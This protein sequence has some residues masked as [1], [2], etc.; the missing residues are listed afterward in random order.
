LATVKTNKIVPV[1]TAASSS[2]RAY[3]LLA[4][5]ALCWAGNMG[6]AS[7]H[8]SRLA[9]D[10]ELL[11]MGRV[12]RCIVFSG[13]T[14]AA[15]HARTLLPHWRL[16][17]AMGAFGL[18]GFGALVYLAA[19]HTSSINLSIIQGSIPVFVLI[20]AFLFQ[21]KRANGWMVVGVALTL[22]GILTI[23]T[24]GEWSR[25]LTLSFNI[26]DVFVLLACVMYAGYAL[27][28]P[29]RPDMPALCS[30]PRWRWWG[31]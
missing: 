16:V 1:S 25:L 15:V 31:R 2:S 27:A 26:G 18:A 3:A 7:R 9:H 19:L 23:A 20:G 5:A 28:L 4:A 22:V 24:Q 11:A 30:L 14:R 29:R 8:R 12:F 21:G 17:A 13:T 6:R 10:I